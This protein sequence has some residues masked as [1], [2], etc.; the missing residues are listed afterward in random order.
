MKNLNKTE[1][2]EEKKEVVPPPEQ[3]EI[4]TDYMPGFKEALDGIYSTVFGPLTFNLDDDKFDK[5]KSEE[6]VINKMKDELK[7]KIKD[8]KHGFE[9][10][11]GGYYY[12]TL[13]KQKNITKISK[14]GLLKYSR[15]IQ[16]LC[17]Q[18]I[19]PPEKPQEEP[20]EEGEGQGE[21]ERSENE[22]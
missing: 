22:A 20:K 19:V 8:C 11:M 5:E 7:D 1:K 12:K 4:D 3:Q 14:R 13:G 17:V 15:N 10:K 16:N 6:M 9:F 2:E 21:G 18:P